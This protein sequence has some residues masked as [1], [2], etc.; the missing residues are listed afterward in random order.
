M[1]FFWAYMVL[2][3]S[4]VVLFRKDVWYLGF[5]IIIKT[6]LLLKENG[7]ERVGKYERNSWDEFFLFTDS[8][9]TVYQLIIRIKKSWARVVEVANDV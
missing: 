3:K 5:K 1:Y 4:C 6:V 2:N 9:K 8:I 7:G